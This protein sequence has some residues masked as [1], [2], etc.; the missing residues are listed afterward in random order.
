MKKIGENPS[1][2]TNET[3]TNPLRGRMSLYPDNRAKY[4]SFAGGTDVTKYMHFTASISP[5][6]LRQD[7]PFLPY[8]I[9]TANLTCGR[10]GELASHCF[11]LL[12]PGTFAG[13]QEA[14]AIEYSPRVT[15]FEKFYVKH[16]TPP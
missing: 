15:R 1:R 5:G 9:N 6:W 4:F 10:A 3:I 8:T 11:P 13:A 2:L 7:E 12:T 16:P 14:L